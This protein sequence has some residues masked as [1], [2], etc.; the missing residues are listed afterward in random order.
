M[1]MH[2]QPKKKQ[3]AYLAYSTALISRMTFTLISPG[4]F[5]SAC[6]LF[7]ISARKLERAEVVHFFRNDEHAELAAG[8]NCVGTLSRPET[9][10]QSSQGRRV[11]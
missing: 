9:P 8:G 5:N 1:Q 3:G 10:S 7:A 11:A 6:I 2:R 4:Y